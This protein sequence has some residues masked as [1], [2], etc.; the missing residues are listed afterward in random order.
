M[1]SSI[2]YKCISLSKTPIN[3]YSTRD[4]KIIYFK[5][6]WIQAWWWLCL[7]TKQTKDLPQQHWPVSTGRIMA[8]FVTRASSL[9]FSLLFNKIFWTNGSL[10]PWYINVSVFVR[11]CLCN[12]WIPSLQDG[13]DQTFLKP[14]FF[15]PLTISFAS[16]PVQ[17]FPALPSLS[18]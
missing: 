16:V 8:L 7:N 6:P 11:Q 2:K 5:P 17:L 3:W 13:L 18:Y 14:L 9:W 10:A 12:V 4:E 15:C 1:A